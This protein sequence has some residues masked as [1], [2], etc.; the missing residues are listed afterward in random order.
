MTT[1]LQPTQVYIPSALFIRPTLVIGLGGTGVDVI[2][3]LKR[4]IRQSMQPMPGVLEFLVVDTE[5]PQNM[6]GKERILDREIAYIGDFNA[7]KV[8]DHLD[9]HPHIK[10]WWPSD[11]VVTGSIFR[12]ARQ[13][14]LVGRL[15]LY[16]RWG[17]FAHRLDTK[18]DKIRQIAE[19][20]QVE[21]QGIRTERTGQVRVYIVSSLCGGTGSGLLLDVAFRVRSKLGDDGEICGV[22][23]MPSVFL[24]E[25]ASHIQR[26][27]IQGN[28]YAAL[29]ELNYYLSGQQQFEATFP[30]Y[31]YQTPD[32][33]KQVTYVRR[34]FDT[35]FLVD[36]DNGSEGLSSIDEVKQMIS[37][38][39]YLDTVT[40]IGREA[41]SK[42]ENLNDLASEHQNKFALAIAGVSTA[43]LVLPV[44]PVQVHVEMM[45]M[46]I[47]QEHTLQE[48]N[49]AVKDSLKNILESINK[50]LQEE[51][52]D[53]NIEKLYKELQQKLK[54]LYTE[55]GLDHVAS[56]ISEIQLEP[57]DS[58][59]SWLSR[60][61]RK[62]FGKNQV[63]ELDTVIN[64]LRKNIASIKNVSD[65]VRKLRLYYEDWQ[66]MMQ[67]QL[68]N[69]VPSRP[70]SM[71]EPKS[72]QNNLSLFELVTEL[73]YEREVP[74]PGN[75]PNAQW[76]IDRFVFS[77]A[78]LSGDNKAKLI[79][80][81]GLH[82]VF[83]LVYKFEKGEHKL[84]LDHPPNHDPV[85]AYLE[86]FQGFVNP[87]LSES[88]TA[89]RYLRWFYNNI[90]YY[91]NTSTESRGSPIDPL[92]HL[93]LRSEKPFLRI[94][95]ARLGTEHAS[96]IE[97]QRLIGYSP[98]LISAER[99]DPDN[100]LSDFD[101]YYHVDTGTP[102][103]IDILVISSGYRIADLRDLPELK[104][105][106]EYFMKTQ[107]ET[108]HIHKNWSHGRL[109]DLV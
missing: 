41:A 38:V 58:D 52:T 98:L 60:L 59:D 64:S 20:E 36:R 17:Q 40:P 81:I 13:R 78:S 63:S 79:N 9:Q 14:R 6:P 95:N 16:A 47:L 2:R 51:L 8:L 57:N 19:N 12:G 66:A 84:F 10:D 101:S 109:P 3:Q 87:M 90:Q 75:L 92:R 54:D 28:A 105:A 22:F 27:R 49:S 11:Q 62:I 31:A 94:D 96:D 88:W 102:N 103:R 35:V 93:K 99:H 44:C 56:V 69:V 50:W 100:V 26:L 42:R 45:A 48:Q 68:S 39:I 46:R 24:Q 65:F 1:T 37:Q 73:G 108:L 5:M 33:A 82:A 53:E 72:L 7:G 86:T 30:D 104:K 71:S 85:K 29:K 61:K 70:Q 21:K 15:S 23:V 55:K 106:Y 18:L 91:S 67:Q 107:R 43:S 77:L 25:I 97:V 89:I 83:N 34:P 4:R 80:E 32:G 74:A 76:P